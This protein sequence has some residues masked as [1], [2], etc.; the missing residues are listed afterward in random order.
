M[1]PF[2]FH[3]TWLFEEKNLD[4]YGAI[5]APT[6]ADAAK[7]IEQHYGDDLIEVRLYP[8]EEGLL[9]M[10]QTAYVAIKEYDPYHC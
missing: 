1:F 10:P 5:Y 8:L 4:D 3:V 9:L 2:L 7:Q 6:F